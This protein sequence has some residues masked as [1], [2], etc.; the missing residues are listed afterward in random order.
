MLRLP[1]PRPDFLLSDSV[2]TCPPLVVNFTNRSKNYLTWHWD[3]GDGNT[4]SLPNP[5][6]FYA[7]VGT[8]NVV[9][10]VTGATGCTSQKTKQ[11]KVNGPTGSFTY[12]NLVGCTPLATSFKAHTGKNISF[13]WDFNDGTTISTKDSA[14]QHVYTSQGKYLPKM[15]LEDASGCKVPILGKDSIQVFGVIASFERQAGLLCDSGTAKFNN[16]SINNDLIV[17]Y[18]WNFGDG[19]TSTQQDPSHQY[20]QPGTY[21]TTLSVVTQRGC[22]DT[23]GD[24]SGLRIHSSRKLP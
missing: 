12:S 20:T 21:K 13:V 3:F 2:G 18:L 9:L 7:S 1:I 6:H 19:K 23:A 14:A 4:S 22:K 16:T 10:T 17:N 15:I 24:P 8:F 5:S 11:I